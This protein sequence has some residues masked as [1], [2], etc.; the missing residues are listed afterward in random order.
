MKSDQLRELSREE[1]LQKRQELEEELFNLRIRRSVR[2]LDNPL[3]LRIAR[4]EKA[5]INTILWE[6]EKRIRLVAT[7]VAP[8]D[9]LPIKKKKE[10]APE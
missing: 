7:G 9:S 5:R 8:G 1:L 3:R 4:R 10:S 2:Q 6:D